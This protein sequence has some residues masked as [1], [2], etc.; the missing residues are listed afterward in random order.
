MKQQ[1]L[2]ESL[3]AA[4][5]I[6]VIWPQPRVWDLIRD[7]KCYCMAVNESAIRRLASER[8]QDLHDLLMGTS[9]Y[10]RPEEHPS[11]SSEASG[12]LWTLAVHYLLYVIEFGIPVDNEGRWVGD[13]YRPSHA[14]EF[15]QWIAIGAP[16]LVSEELNCY[17]NANPLPSC[18]A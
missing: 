16:G 4:A 8:P 5:Q 14:Q 7:K 9:Q 3:L 15:D 13:R 18:D 10:C 11:I 1:D 2:M 17:L 12:I 6:K